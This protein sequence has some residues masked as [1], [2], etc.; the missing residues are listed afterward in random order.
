MRETIFIIHFFIACD[1]N[2]IDWF[3]F[4]FL[5]FYCII[6]LLCYRFDCVSV[7]VI[8]LLMCNY[9]CCVI[10]FVLTLSLM[11]ISKTIILFNST[12]SSCCA[13]CFIA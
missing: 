4:C 1:Y 2:V 12:C 11:C 5:V 3:L 13:C 8:F 10:E 9:D 6:V 7:L